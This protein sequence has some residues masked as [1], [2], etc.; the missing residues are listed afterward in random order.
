MRIMLGSISVTS[1]LLTFIISTV[2]IVPYNAK[3]G[4]YFN[5]FYGYI[6]GSNIYSGFGSVEDDS[7]VAWLYNGNSGSAHYGYRYF[8]YSFGSVESFYNANSARLYNDRD[9][10]LNY[11]HFCNGFASF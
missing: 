4:R 10:Q 3:D 1:V 5:G 11:Y 6:D 2:G 8:Y 7:N 9:S